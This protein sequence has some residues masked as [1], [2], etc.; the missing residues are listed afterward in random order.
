MY[1]D[2]DDDDDDDA[3]F[4]LDNDLSHGRHNGSIDSAA[5]RISEGDDSSLAS[6]ADQ[7]S[8][9]RWKKEDD[10]ENDK[11]LAPS[12]ARKQSE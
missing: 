10:N 8:E 9:N 5:A 11:K 6:S 1:D 12:S 7:D 3:T 4:E 2:D